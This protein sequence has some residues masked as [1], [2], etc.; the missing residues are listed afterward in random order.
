MSDQAQNT[1]PAEA[2][3][4]PEVAD[5]FKTE[6]QAPVAST[7][8][9]TSDV[10]EST[11]KDGEDKTKENKTE[12]TEKT[13]VEVKK[14]EE[15]TKDEAKPTEF[16]VAGT[17]YS[18]LEK[19]IEAVNRINGDN[20]RLAGDTKA[21]K[22]D[23]GEL[24]TKVADLEKLLDNYKTANDQWK[25]YYEEGGEKPDTSKVDLEEVIN[26]KLK[27]VKEQEKKISTQEQFSTELDEIFLE[28]DFE[29][30]KPFFQELIDEYDGVPKA[31]P[32]KLYERAQILA[33]KDILKESVDIDKMVDERVEKRLAQKEAAKNTT[34]S[35]G[36]ANKSEDYSDM[37]P[38]VAEYFKQRQ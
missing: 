1:S 3:L 4:S 18:T 24:Q 25:E 5:Y 38:E 37:S 30:V 10:T 11:K 14:G 12:K 2:S 21:L 33:K 34:V 27:E 31:N 32:R 35:G 22:K 19:A 17:K 23:K 15:A 20:S 16:E 13:P 6:N 36:S 26:K 28:P 8:K 9:V 29:K 7:E